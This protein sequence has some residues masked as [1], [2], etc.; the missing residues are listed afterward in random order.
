MQSP[1][2][3]AELSDGGDPV[4][5][6]EPRQHDV[7]AQAAG[8]RGVAFLRDDRRV[9]EVGG[10]PARVELDPD[11][12]GEGPID[13]RGGSAC[14]LHGEHARPGGREPRGEEVAAAAR[15]SADEGGHELRNDAQGYRR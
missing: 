13:D 3:V 11:A 12:A 1:E 4:S 15:P 2:L 14:D 10:K 8:G 6:R 9:D 5:E 7:R